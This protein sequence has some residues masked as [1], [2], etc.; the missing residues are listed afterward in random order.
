MSIE[1]TKNRDIFLK[2]CFMYFLNHILV[3][4]GINEEIVDL[5]PTEEI[6]I[7]KRR[8][9]KIFNNFLDFKALTKSGKILI[10]EFKKHSLRKRDMKQVF[11][12]YINEFTNMDKV[13]ELILIVLTDRG[14]IKEYSEAQL[15]FTPIVIK[16]KKIN[17][18][19]DLKTI[20]KKFIND[21]KLTDDESS[22]LIALPLFDIDESESEIVEEICKCIK[23]RKGSIPED[24]LD[25]VT[26]AM[27]LNI[28][29]YID[30]DM[31]DEL[32]EMIDMAEKIEGIMEQIRKEGKRDMII[33]MLNFHSLKEIPGI[34]HM[35]ESEVLNILEK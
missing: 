19:K 31:Q 14:R 13:V 5:L 9:Q 1:E 17:K 22:L 23:H 33:H 16:T 18:R 11:D 8:K 12:Y 3:V 24:K 26:I 2:F 27:Y 29:E 4:L 34:L 7:K 6:T 30:E 35:K 10:F 28:L 25:E 32:L 15:T 20:K 21:K